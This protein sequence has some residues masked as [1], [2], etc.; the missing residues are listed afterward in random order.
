MEQNVIGE[1]VSNLSYIMDRNEQQIR[2]NLDAV[3]MSTQFT[4]SD[5]GLIDVLTTA[6]EGEQYSTS[7]LIRIYDEDVAMLE[8]LINN[9]P[10]LY[11]V[12]VYA[13]SDNVQEMMPVIFKK[14]RM[15]KLEWAKK[16]D[17]YGWHFGYADTLFSTL[18]SEDNS[19]LLSLVTEIKD[20]KHGTIGTIEVAMNMSTMFPSLY[21]EESNTWSGFW[22]EDKVY[23]K[24]DRQKWIDE[25]LLARVQQSMDE[26]FAAG[27]NKDTY[28][29]KD[30]KNRYV[31]SFLYV[32]ELGGTLIVIRDITE[33]VNSI[34]IS[35]SIFIAVAFVIILLLS[36]GVRFIVT[37]TLRQFY[38]ILKTMKQVEAGDLN[39]R[40]EKCSGDEMGLLGNRLNRMLDEIQVLMQDGITREVLMKNTEIRALQNQINAH[41]IYNSLESIKMMAEIDEE[42]DISDAITALGKLLRYSMRWVS[43]NVLVSEELEYIQNY[44]TLMNLRFDYKII[45]SLNI[46]DNVKQQKIPKMSLQ[47]IVENAIVHGI[48]EVAEDT[49]IYLKGYVNNKDCYIEISDSG[50]GMTE[51]QVAKLK[52]KISGQIEDGGGSGN[53]IGLKNVQDRIIIAFGPEYGI[54][55]SS[56][57]NCYTKIIVHLPLMTE[58]FI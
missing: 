47:P 18:E 9:N 23:Y 19:Q 37:R 21:E 29:E 39:V 20:F 51:E 16:E 42:Y 50:K 17:V 44:I 12:R 48:E 38:E 4:K 24:A 52:K 57:V 31:V 8:R 32:K 46:P 33:A 45:L 15:E 30:G 53:G 34:Y 41:F 3:N 43:G 26:A 58:D 49:T 10:L 5:V 56:K 35:R 2:T 55:I 28:F 6:A 1:N 13:S 11:S 22:T 14:S 40:I 25:E 7:E 36:V 27:T 54:D